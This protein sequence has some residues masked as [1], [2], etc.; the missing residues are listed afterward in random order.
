MKKG[1]E[2]PGWRPLHPSRFTL[3]QVW[4]EREGFEPSIGVYP[5]C[6]FSKPVPSATRPPLQQAGNFAKWLRIG[7]G[8]KH[9]AY[10]SMDS[11]GSRIEC[12]TGACVMGRRWFY[13]CEKYLNR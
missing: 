11:L 6:R 12:S 10:A 1:E 3:H 9:L 4:T 8:F 13:G 2:V 7:K 5:L